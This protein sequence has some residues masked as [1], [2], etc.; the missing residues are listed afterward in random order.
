MMNTVW[1]DTNSSG[2]SFYVSPQSE[3]KQTFKSERGRLARMHDELARRQHQHALIN[4]YNSRDAM[5]QA[6]N[7]PIV[8]SEP[9]RQQQNGSRGGGGQATNQ[10]A[11]NFY[12]DESY[13]MSESQNRS[14]Q[15]DSLIEYH[16]QSK[17]QQQQLPR[18]QSLLNSIQNAPPPPQAVNNSTPFPADELRKKYLKRFEESNRGFDDMYAKTGGDLLLAINS[19]NNYKSGQQ[20]Q[21]QQQQQTSG[22]QTNAVYAERLKPSFVRTSK[23]KQAA[24]NMFTSHIDIHLFPGKVFCFFCNE[25][26]LSLASHS[27]ASFPNI[28]LIFRFFCLSKP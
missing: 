28:K 1:H 22:T 26:V 17:Q 4:G 15:A 11:L 18:T 3:Y 5:I 27:F 6:K 8:F 20:Q 21:Q 7:V 14:G 10:S 13:T 25:A 19:S 2:L 16:R 9:Y 24:R 12:L 23:K